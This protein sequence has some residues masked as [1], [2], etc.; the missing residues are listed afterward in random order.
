[1]S[2]EKGLDNNVA[3]NETS[4][5]TAEKLE[6][7]YLQA[8]KE[9]FVGLDEGGHD[10]WVEHIEPKEDFNFT[11]D[12]NQSWGEEFS[13]DVVDYEMENN[14]TDLDFDLTAIDVF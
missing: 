4:Q 14:F 13:N 7:E 5:P 9:A 10:H 1:M 6:Q 8:F 11:A 2:Q 3:V 12:Q